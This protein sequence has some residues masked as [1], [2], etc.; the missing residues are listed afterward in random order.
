MTPVESSL[1]KAAMERLKARREALME[2]LLKGRAPEFPHEHA[3]MLDEY[4]HQS[5]E[6]SKAG[7]RLITRGQPYTLV[8]LGGYGRREQ[9]LHSD[10]DLLFLFERSVPAEAAQLVEE[11]AYPL[12]DAGLEVGHATRSLEDCIAEA[13]ENLEVL[14]AALDARFICGMSPLYTRLMEALRERLLKDGSDKIVNQ[15][16]ER[17]AERHRKFGDSANLLEPNLKEGVGGLRDYHTVLWIARI[18]NNLT[19]PRD[20][21]YYGC[22]SHD[23]YRNLT[24]ALTFIWQV[25]NR[26]HY[27]AGRKWDKLQFQYQERIADDLGYRKKEGQ[28]PVERFLGELH[29][30]MEFLKEQESVRVFEIETG[31]KRGRCAKTGQTRYE[32]IECE[33][34]AIRF[35][36]SEAVYERPILI[37]R[38]FEES[39]RL[40]LPLSTEAKRLVRDFGHR[41]GKR[42][43]NDPKVIRAFES[44]LL[45][46][47][48][49][50]NVLEAMHFTGFLVRFIPEFDQ[51]VNRI[52]YDEYHIYPVDRHLLRTLIIL[53]SFGSDEPEIPSLCHQLW[54][55]SKSPL[56]LIWATLLHDIGKGTPGGDHSETGAEIARSL[57]LEKRYDEGFADTVAFLIRHHLL[58][59]ITATRRDIQDEETAIHCARIVGDAERLKMLYLLA[60][61]DSMATGPKAWNS[62]TDS[63]LQQLF[64]NV[65]NILENGELASGE[66]IRVVESK[67]AELLNSAESPAD[68]AELEHLLYM[69]SP[70]YLLYTD[71]AAMRTHVDLFRHMNAN[72]A[73]FAWNVETVG[74]SDTRRVTICAKDAPGLFSKIAG[75]FTLHHFYVLNAQVFTWRNNVALDVFTV[76]SPP[77]KIFESRKW[78][79]AETDLG[80]AL[81]GELDLVAALAEKQEI[82]GHSRPRTLERPHSIHIDNKSS[83]FF[84]ILEIY[85]YDSPGVLYGIT[86]ALFQCG[87]DIWV[88]KIA[89]QIDQ[90]VDVF[91]VRDF[92]GQK[93]DTPEEEAAIR[94]AVEAVLPPGRISP[95]TISAG[96]E[97][98]ERAAAEK[99][100]SQEAV[101]GGPSE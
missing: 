98:R 90:V 92:D 99:R 3:L 19:Q 43:R 101:M 40:K 6:A 30:H 47:A 79:A 94:S 15:L 51:V 28:Q 52:Q 97:P 57:L 80:D 89:T 31:K 33:N 65:L 18:Q 46:R 41:L 8:A 13:D 5:Y 93:V 37:I 16:I 64:L 63:L 91:Y 56:I 87:L 58:L 21:E 95:E 12:W 59:V 62:W 48:D 17:N 45:T 72:A 27:L 36:S 66:T 7:P 44:I 55:E 2:R 70:R 76:R 74:P 49:R 71:P 75:V 26:L 78:A 1:I 29:R 24:E 42:F 85:T 11:I 96:T 86:R 4:F 50:F 84:T 35:V 25:R 73:P 68:R 61:A 60:A 23:E 83:S 39:A 88:A 38:A 10:V 34:G 9:C 82:Y 81:K 67:K 32:G 69:M 53:K 20:L 77:D 100:S 54:K 22:L 14:T